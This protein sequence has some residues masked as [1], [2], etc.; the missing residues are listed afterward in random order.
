MFIYQIQPVLPPS[1]R[2]LP[3]APPLPRRSAVTPGAARPPLTA[4]RWGE[5]R[6]LRSARAAGAAGTCVPEGARGG[7]GR[8]GAG[9]AHPSE[10]PRSGRAGGGVPGEIAA[11][12]SVSISLSLSLQAGPACVCPAR[13]SREPCESLRGWWTCWRACS[14]SGEGA[15]PC[16]GVFLTGFCYFPHKRGLSAVVSAPSHVPYT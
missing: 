5:A 2:Y 6:R 1:P 13:A 3:P 7:W 14:S 16:R 11:P 9:G 12:F 8:A 15:A 10:P 4:P